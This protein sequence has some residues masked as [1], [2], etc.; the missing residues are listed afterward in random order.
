MKPGAALAHMSQLARLGLPSR[1]VVPEMLATLADVVPSHFCMF[2]W[3]DARGQPEDFHLPWIVP[4]AIEANSRLLGANDGFGSLIR[5]GRSAADACRMP[6][7]LRS[8]FYNE[9]CRPYGIGHGF[10]VPIREDGAMCGMLVA[11]RAPKSAL[12]SRREADLLRSVAP[13]FAHALA[14]DHVSR[15]DRFAPHGERTVLTVD[16]E[17]NVLEAGEGHE[18]L[19]KAALD[20]HFGAGFRTGIFYAAARDLLRPLVAARQPA[21]T[22]D[23]RHGRITIRLYPAVPAA[24]RGG[25][26]PGH[27][28]VLIERRHPLALQAAIG[29]SRLDLSTREREVARHIVLGHPPRQVMREVGIGAHTLHDYRRRIYR[30]LAIS[31]REELAARVLG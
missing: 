2:M 1:S 11:T 22:F 18:G 25:R 15:A 4:D 14:A 7:F 27:M 29:V 17:G 26:G 31:S 21:T 12:F 10:D 13:A 20:A 9:C 30:R 28:F 6:E 3:T 24:G 5:M 23:T 19:L 16:A 8:P